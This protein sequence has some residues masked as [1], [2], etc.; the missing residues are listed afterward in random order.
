MA[1]L[2]IPICCNTGTGV[3]GG[4]MS[5]LE[6][7]GT[8][9]LDGAAAEGMHL[10]LTRE[11]L[12]LLS[13]TECVLNPSHLFERLLRRTS[14]TDSGALALLCLLIAA[15]DTSFPEEPEDPVVTEPEEV[16]EE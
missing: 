16:F 5:F 3:G 7:S 12:A 2:E 15:S 4:I 9:W 11:A 10:G 8:P 6:E 13:E 1:H 14:I